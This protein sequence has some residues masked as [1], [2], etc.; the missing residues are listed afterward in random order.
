M[1]FCCCHS[2]SSLRTSTPFN[3][4]IMSWGTYW[5]KKVFF[6]R[7]SKIEHFRLMFFSCIKLAK[8]S[9]HKTWQKR[10]DLFT[11]VIRWLNFP[12]VNSFLFFNLSKI[13]QECNYVHCDQVWNKSAYSILKNV[14]D[15]WYCLRDK[16]NR[17]KSKNRDEKSSRNSYI[18]KN[19]N[20]FFLI[21]FR[22]L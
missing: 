22:I 4:L 9:A 8:L 19:F 14:S 13:L 16:K 15:F 20:I 21:F 3:S 18:G 11:S 17:K 10:H 7:K 2:C 12:R 5:K 6:K 1:L